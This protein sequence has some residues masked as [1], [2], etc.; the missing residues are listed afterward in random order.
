[1]FGRIKA[2]FIDNEKK[3]F[4]IYKKRYFTNSFVNGNCRTEKQ[5]EASITRF[6]HTIEKG[7][8]YLNYRP[9]FGHDVM[10]ILISEMEEYSK[11]YDIE[12]FFYKTALSTLFAY[13]KKNKENGGGVDEKLKNRIKSLPGERNN[14]GG[15]FVFK[16]LKKV[17][18]INFEEMVKNRHSMRHFST[19]P[20]NL[21]LVEKAV[22]LA[23]YTPSAC[24]RQGWHTY[25]INDKNVIEKVLNN[26]NGNRGFGQEFDKLL[27]VTGDLQ[28]FNRDREVFQVFIDGGMYAMRVLDSLCYY[29][30]ATCPLSAS[31]FPH[32]EKNVR[33]ILKLT[34]SE[35]LI[36]FIGIGNYPDICQTT[37]SQRHEP[38]TVVI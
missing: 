13:I 11:R 21:E 4:S 14:E 23:Q 28:Y 2:L 27:V 19:T 36:M 7:L 34:D 8:A 30:I 3:A 38:Y 6:Y 25:I 26:Q 10:D 18:D 37:K 1:M 33:E 32:Q 5:Y 9:G 16:P 29:G 24:N 17:S 31:L 35:V 20:L 15:C 12:K 22:N